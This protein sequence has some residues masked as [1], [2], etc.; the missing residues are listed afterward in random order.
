MHWIQ[1][2]GIIIGGISVGLADALIKKAAASGNIFSAFWNPFML[3]GIFLY[4]LQI[5]FIT[6]AFI[7]KW[8]LGV[9]GIL[10]VV[11][12]SITVVL[13]GILFFNEGMAPIK[14]V[15]IVLAVIGIVLMNL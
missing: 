15:G 2:L 3:G 10:E 12:Y 9:T 14:G 5:L 11:F 1:L 7:K 4:V 8:E 6:Y 13:A